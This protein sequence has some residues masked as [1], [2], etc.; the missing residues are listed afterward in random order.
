MFEV[1]GSIFKWRSHDRSPAARGASGARGAQG[2]LGVGGSGMRGRGREAGRRGRGDDQRRRVRRA[3]RGRCAA[4]R[5]VLVSLSP[6]SPPHSTPRTLHPLP[7]TP[8]VVAL[9]TRGPWL[10]PG[11]PSSP[12]RPCPC[13]ASHP[14]PPCFAALARQRRRVRGLRLRVLP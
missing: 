1:R 9:A 8:A 14:S 12:T 10:L 4:G 7:T 11:S 2:G 6:A 3:C 13:R 5:A